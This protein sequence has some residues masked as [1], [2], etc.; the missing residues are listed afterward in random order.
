MTRFLSQSRG[1]GNLIGRVAG[2][3]LRFGFSA[4]RFQRRLSRFQRIAA[5]H[6][7]T[8]TFAI[9][10]VTL[11]R[12]PDLIRSLSR[13]G[14]E[15][16]VHG[17]VHSDYRTMRADRQV[18]H[19]RKAID[20]FHECQVPYVGFRAPYL[21]INGTMPAAIGQAGLSYDSSCVVCWDVLDRS[22]Y[23]SGRWR[24]YERLLD[25][26]QPRPA[27]GYL[28]LP[29]KADG[30]IEIPVSIPDDE[31]MIDRL[32]TC[33]DEI[34]EVWQAILKQTYD[35]GELFTA[36]IHP[37]RI[38]VCENPLVGTLQLAKRLAPHVWVPTLGEI[39]GW[40]EEKAEFSLRVEDAGGER[41]RVAATCS[42]R[43]T[44][45]TRDCRVDG[46]S[47][48]WAKDYRCVEATDFVVECPT[49]PV[50]GVAADTAAEAKDFLRSE[51]YAFEVTD[52]GSRHGIYLGDLAQFDEADEKSL[53]ERIETSAAPIVRFW[54]WPNR[55]RSVMS[56]S[57]D[58]DAMTLS[59]FALRIVENVRRD[60]I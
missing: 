46:P 36:Q 13:Q 55:A 21:R 51:G 32:G 35:R 39:A 34:T 5:E 18:R 49:R 7:C 1:I 28:A 37:E 25:F 17:Y 14:V 23:A 52:D 58:I 47:M 48:E 41:W 45:L 57:G 43:A 33:S 19:L 20:V 26:Y 22:G 27:A 3:L 24:E 15:F 40:W 44:L 8:P 4:R 50:I 53:V 56:V 60:S 31:A 54:R 42:D 9:T 29:R 30:L 11:R 59:D 12:H 16:A 2:I 38:Y 6:G 10:A